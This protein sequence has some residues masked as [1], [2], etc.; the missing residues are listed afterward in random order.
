MIDI[1]PIT[2]DIGIRYFPKYE[3]RTKLEPITIENVAPSAAPAE[4]P[5]KPGSARGFL[6]SPCKEAPDKPKLAPTK[7]DRKTLGNLTSRKTTSLSVILLSVMIS[8]ISIFNAPYF[9]DKITEIIKI[10]KR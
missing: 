10:K 9:I 2:A 6:K 8:R 4:T 3:S 5:I 1:E 7:H